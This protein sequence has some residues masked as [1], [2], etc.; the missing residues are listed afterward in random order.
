MLIGLTHTVSPNLAQG[1]VTYIDRAP[2]DYTLALQQHDQ[3]CSTLAAHGVEVKKLAMNSDYPDSCFV[4]DTTIVLDEIVIITRM[5]TASRRGE[6]AGIAAEIS[7]YRE[8]VAIEQPASIEG[9]DV[10]RIGKTL[11]VGLSTRTNAQGIEALTAIVQYFGYKVIPVSV[12][13]CLHLKTACTAVSDDTLLINPLWIETAP[14]QDFTLLPVSPDEQWAANTIRVNDTLFVQAGFPS[15]LE[16][17]RKFT[18]NIELLNISEFR[19][20]EAGLSCLSIL[21]QK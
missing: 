12:T 9:G 5:G 13:G 15:M 18:T 6:T 7:K 10:L 16:Q 17:V 11:F 19:K 14:L 8:T 3:Y 21:F 20:V 2:V 1:E 4:E